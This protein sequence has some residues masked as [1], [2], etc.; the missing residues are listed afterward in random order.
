MDSVGVQVGLVLG[1]LLLLE[2]L[3]AARGWGGLSAAGIPLLTWLVFTAVVLWCEAMLAFVAVHGLLFLLGT[4]VAG[5]GL[6]L[7][8]VGLVITP[9][10]TA[11]LIRRSSHH[12]PVQH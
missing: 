8:V 6:L 10:A 4:D 3:A 9:F 1:F 5:V 11:Y 2:R 12:A 7:T